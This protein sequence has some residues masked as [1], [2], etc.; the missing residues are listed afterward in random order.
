MPLT[1]AIAARLDEIEKKAGVTARDVAQLLDI[2]PETIS[3]WRNGKS[4]PQPD[5]RD[6]LLLLE[7]LVIELAELY[8]PQEAQLW[9]FSPHRSLGGERPSD[10]IQRGDLESGLKIIAQLKDGA[11]V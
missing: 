7:W 10:R 11:Y 5:K 9:L 1:N 2:R 3:R 8:P 4:E 6:R